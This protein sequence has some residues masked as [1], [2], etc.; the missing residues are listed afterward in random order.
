[1][2]DVLYSQMVMNLSSV[3]VWRAIWNIIDCLLYPDNSLLSDIVSFAVGIT[4]CCVMLAVQSPIDLYM[5]RINMSTNQKL[6]VES[7]MYI[8]GTWPM[9]FL[10]RGT[11]NLCRTIVLPDPFV[12]GYFFHIF[13][14]I[15]L[16]TLQGL[17]N[18]GSNNIQLDGRREQNEDV[19]YFRVY[20][21]SR[22]KVGGKDDRETVG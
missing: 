6:A 10:W 9:L 7:I 2:L 22:L 4:F 14:T 21:P 13:G 5:R 17:S 12:G 8:I 11:W 19:F 16:V 18:V 3:A 1:M 20:C 15:G